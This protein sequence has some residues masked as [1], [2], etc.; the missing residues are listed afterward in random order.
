MEPSDT[1][2][3][4]SMQAMKEHG[5][6]MLYGRWLIEGAP[7]VLLIDIRWG[8]TY[9]DQWKGNLWDLARI[10][11]PDSDTETNEAV[12]FGYL[13]IWFLGEVGESI[14]MNVLWVTLKDHVLTLP[15]VCSI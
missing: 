13:V 7:R 9:L 3:R 10:P 1:H 14:Y 6:R 12:I 8:Y 11:T 4:A 5:I 15:H 2:I